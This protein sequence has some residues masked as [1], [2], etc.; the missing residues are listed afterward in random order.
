[1][2]SRRALFASLS[3][4]ALVG[5][6]GVPRL[7]PEFLNAQIHEPYTLD[8]GDRLRVIVFGQDS[9]SNSYGVDGAGRISMPLIGLI[10]AR[11]RTTHQLQASI[12][13]RLRA[14]FLREPR[15]SVEVEQYRPFFVLGEVN[16]SGQ[17]PFVNQMT[18][19][20]AVAI[21]G[22]FSPRANRNYAEL[23]RVISG[24]ITTVA[25][26]INTPMRPGDTIVIRERFF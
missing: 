4:A 15:V 24:E 3:L 17:Y 2:I 14:G 18:V 12:E 25:V 7:T 23:T 9:L 10:D 6:A 26:P 13:G 8:A 22:G 11:G 20:M 5:C 16:T 19:Q 21:A 1:M